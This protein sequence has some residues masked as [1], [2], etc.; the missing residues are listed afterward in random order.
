MI[1]KKSLSNTL[2]NAVNYTVLALFAI[3]CLLPFWIMLVASFTDDMA[4]RKNGYLPWITQFSAAAYKWVFAGQDIQI[5][6]AVTVFVTVVG[7]IGALV[8]MSGVAYVMSLKRLKFR[9]VFAFYCFIP[10]I[11][12]PGIVPWFIITRNVWGLKDNIWALIF[13]MMMQPF[14]VFVLRNFFAALP[15]EIMESAYIDGASD[16]TILYQIVLPLSKPV[17]ATV[18]LF[19]AVAYWNDWYLGVMLLDFAPFKPL[20]VLILKMVNNAQAILTAMKQPGV[21][22]RGDTLPTLSIR[23]ATAVITIGPIILVYPF[24]QRYFVQGLT[25][26]AIKG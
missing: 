24:V 13:P 25:L 23:M 12:S 26:G 21:V 22:I 8:A 10:M 20:S 18:G 15:S 1:E 5:G 16:A 17:L 4:L 14:W 3:F 11:F 9:N 6:Y 2:F 19:M 7:T